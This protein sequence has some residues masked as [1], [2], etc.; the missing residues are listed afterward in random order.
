MSKRC[1]PSKPHLIHPVYKNQ[2]SITKTTFKRAVKAQAFKLAFY[3]L[4]TFWGT[5]SFCQTGKGSEKAL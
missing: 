3:L 5:G 2:I 4:F 1:E